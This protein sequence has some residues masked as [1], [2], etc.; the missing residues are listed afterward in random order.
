MNERHLDT[1]SLS[2]V[3]WVDDNSPDG[4]GRLLDA[5]QAPY[6]TLRVMHRPRK[7]GL[8]TAYRDAFRSLLMESYAFFLT[9]DADLSHRPESI[10]DLL[11]A[12]EQSDLVVGTRYCEGKICRFIGN[13]S[14]VPQIHLRAGY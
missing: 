9:M 2:P 10:P 14:V 1:L 8:G 11:Q 4:T 12:A 13:F 6:P 5:L 7:L 3:F